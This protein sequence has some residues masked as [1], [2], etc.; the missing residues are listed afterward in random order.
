[1][2]EQNT[3]FSFVVNIDCRQSKILLI[4]Y[5]FQTIDKWNK[6]KSIEHMK[7]N[8]NRLHKNFETVDTG[9]KQKKFFYLFLSININLEQTHRYIWYAPLFL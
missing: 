8:K 9:C 5:G 7:T 4:L 1:M 2:S 6:A 3:I